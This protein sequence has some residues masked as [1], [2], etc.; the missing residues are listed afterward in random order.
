MTQT[1]RA[2]SQRT[3]TI[4]LGIWVLA[5]LVTATSVALFAGH[6]PPVALG[7]GLA[8]VLV[9][10]GLPLLRQPPAAPN[11][12]NVASLERELDR[13]RRGYERLFTSVP[14]FI[15]VL[16]REHQILEANQLYR[17]EFGATDRSR[18]YEICKGRT[19]KCPDCLVDQTFEDGEVF[20]SEETLVTRDGRRISAVVYTRPIYDDDGEITSV[21]EVFTDITE[22]K[23]LQGRLALMGRAVAGMAHRVK[24]ILMGLEGGIFVVNEGLE[25]GD[26]E[27]ISEGWEMVERNVELVSRIVKDLLYCAKERTPDFNHNVSPER[28]V[29]DVQRLFADR[30]AAENI[31][32]ETDIEEPF[33][34][35]SFDADGLHNLLCN[36]V[37]NAV[38]ACRFDHADDKDGHTITMRCRT[39]GDGSTILQVAD[40]GP[41]ISEDVNARVFEDF[42]STKGS[43]GTGIGLLVAQKVAEDH[44]GKVTF[45]SKPG[46][47]TTFTVTIPAAA[48]RTELP[49]VTSS[50]EG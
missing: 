36:L 48:S 26:Q 27:G 14:C 50:I 24:N 18:C 30:L 10:L 20:S 9:A 23:K 2:N 11:S 12:N 45:S 5:S 38:D 15:C 32:L 7:C 39:N 22:I 42:F 28:I 49:V 47:G 4:R 43:E 6:V 44:G 21:M 8:V 25:S 17:E 46:S 31:M 1:G 13:T 33:H 40:D 37:A 19:S 16:D 41:G 3:T 34:T 35:G 29:L